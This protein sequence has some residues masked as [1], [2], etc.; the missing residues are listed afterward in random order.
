MTNA[1]VRIILSK[2]LSEF[3]V[4]ILR[5]HDCSMDNY[6]PSQRSCAVPHLA[7]G[8]AIPSQCGLSP[9]PPALSFRRSSSRLHACRQLGGGGVMRKG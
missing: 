5:W 1:N 3:S 2:T 4:K 7:C 6:A 8:D 9:H